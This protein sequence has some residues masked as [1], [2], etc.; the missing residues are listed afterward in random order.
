[1]WAVID[2]RAPA[3][4]VD[5]TTWRL[6]ATATS[7]P[8][9]PSAGVY[10]QFPMQGVVAVN[11]NYLWYGQRDDATH[12]LT[13][14][15]PIVGW[16]VIPALP[17]PAQPRQDI[18][19]P[20]STPAVVQLISIQAIG[21]DPLDEG[22]YNHSNFTGS[23]FLLAVQDPGGRVEWIR[24][25]HILRTEAPGSAPGGFFLSDTG[26]DAT[27][28]GQ[29]RT[30]W[31]GRDT[32][33]F[34]DPD[35][36]FFPGGSSLLLPVQTELGHAGHWLATG[37][38]VT[39][40]PRSPQAAAVPAAVVPFQMVVRYAASDA[41]AL[42]PGP[43]P[44]ITDANND[45]CSFTT[46]TP[47]TMLRPQPMPV[48]DYALLLHDYDILC[49]DC[50][51]GRDLSPVV[52]T[53]GLPTAQPEPR[54]NLPRLDLLST[55]YGANGKDARV[56]IASQD[57]DRA[58]NP[59]GV[60]CTIDDL[61][62]GGLTHADV[63]IDG[64]EHAGTPANVPPN[65][66]V[67]FFSHGSVVT[68]IGARLAD[69]DDVVAMATTPL[70]DYRLGE[71]GLV[72]I[73]G[74]VFAYERPTAS[75]AI[76]IA[77][78]L[79]TMQSTNGLTNIASIAPI[80]AGDVQTSGYY[81]R[82]IARAQLGNAIG[83]FSHSV[84]DPSD[85]PYLPSPFQWPHWPI[86]PATRLPLGPVLMVGED[87]SQPW[88]RLV[89]QMPESGSPLPAATTMNA[90]NVLISSAAGYP[91]T[92]EVVQLVG[93]KIHHP[94]PPPTTPD[95][96]AGDYAL[97]PWLRGLYN[98]PS[99]A[100]WGSGSVPSIAIGWWPR[101]A[102]ALP[103]DAATTTAA[104]YRSRTYA[105][106]GFPFALYGMYCSDSLLA[107]L[108]SGYASTSLAHIDVDPASLFTVALNDFFIV[109]AHAAANEPIWSGGSTVVQTSMDWS[110][111]RGVTIN[112]QPDHAGQAFDATYD[113]NGCFSTNSGPLPVDGAEVRVT[114]RYARAASGAIRDIADGSGR[115]PTITEAQVRALAPVRILAS[116]SR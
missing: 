24:Y 47:P 85:G 90:P 11:G 4:Q 33:I 22:R 26:F 10:T 45:Y 2:H 80:T 65:G 116:G 68:S 84:G 71:M 64:H 55:L 102:S 61:C 63:G 82:L 72:L 15:S 87:V 9:N 91:G 78:R 73:D 16:P 93:P 52:D 23:A 94:S 104:H 113:G 48:S 83:G 108:P 69:L 40:M 67:W 112:R 115:A 79:A 57:P 106:V 25:D 75:D 13:Q 19:F 95:P 49:G 32:V 21:A 38:V 96:D 56:A 34:A 7:M 37:D 12:S 54:G 27:T 60:D 114:W 92:Q 41:Y 81:G 3:I 88:F 89:A 5:A 28:R 31:A 39:V 97:A 46:P 1:V 17:S 53:A 8:L 6:P 77:Q 59:V 103:H 70:F 50:W 20:A 76:A 110:R 42:G 14:L 105:W 99:T 35:Q 86:L 98:T 58:F 29:G 36:V 44:P 111:Q 107:K 74:E 109:E 100:T 30:A 51:S 18:D 62:A 43:A 66:I 101:Y